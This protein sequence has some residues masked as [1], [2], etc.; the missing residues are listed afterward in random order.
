MQKSGLIEVY[1]EFY[2]FNMANFNFMIKTASIFY[3]NH[4]IGLEKLLQVKKYLSRVEKLNTWSY[5][6]YT[7]IRGDRELC[8]V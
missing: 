4:K 5:Y 6:K 8:P 7:T 1:D 2:I 3:P